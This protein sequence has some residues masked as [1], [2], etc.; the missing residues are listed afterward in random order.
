MNQTSRRAFIG[1]MAIGAAGAALTPTRGASAAAAKPTG[2][3]SLS[4]DAKPISAQERK[5][6][7][8]RLQALMQEKKIAALLVEAGSTL[9]YFTGVRWFQSER[10]TGAIIPANGQTV[11][12]TPFFESPSIQE[13]LQVPADVRPW[14][15]DE[16]PFELIARTLQDSR[17]GAGPLAIDGM[18]RFFIIDAVT[19]A[20]T[21]QRNVIPGSE[22]VR[23]CRMFKT[24][25]EIELLQIANNVTMAAI[26]YVHSRVELGMRTGDLV[27]LMEAAT[28]DLGGSSDF[29]DALINEASA[30]PH[31]S[32]VVQTVR[33]GS[34]ILMDCGCSVHGYRSDITRTWVFGE[35]SARQREVW[36][37]VK[38]GQ[39]LALETAKI[40]VPVGRIDS[41][42]RAYYESKGWKQHYGLPGLSHRTGHG[43]GMDVHEWPYLVRNDDTPL[44]AGMCFSDEPGIYIPGEFGVRLEDCWHMSEQGPKLFTALAKS[45]DDPV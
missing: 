37:T 6:R 2:L 8:G 12:V 36:G 26:R 27:A 11:I 32:K 42:V 41:A 7:L 1:S 3:K 43:I 28:A 9:E 34:T 15:E 38:R 39:E 5:A 19:R 45:I 44:G 22:L 13:M 24:P 10:I 21:G 20:A 30:F 18:T 29:A 4:G 35:P 14:N 23:A 40:G 16:S 25:A 17:F 31:G 33:H